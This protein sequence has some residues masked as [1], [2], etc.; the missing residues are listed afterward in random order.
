MNNRLP[1]DLDRGQPTLAPLQPVA[2]RCT[3]GTCPTVYKSASGSL[4]VQG[5]SVS[6]ERAG[7]AVPD[8]ETLVEI[9]RELLTE[10]LRNLS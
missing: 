5:Y 1:E 7:I 6:P 2:N 4:V 3:S 9:P 8:G 10:A